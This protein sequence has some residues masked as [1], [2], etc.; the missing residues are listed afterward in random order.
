MW[1]I[2][3]LIYLFTEYGV[4]NIKSDLLRKDMAE[5]KEEGCLIIVAF[6]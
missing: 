4:S 6:S 5:Q 3:Q 1:Q 2:V